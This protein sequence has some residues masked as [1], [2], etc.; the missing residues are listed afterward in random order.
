M[1]FYHLNVGPDKCFFIFENPNSTEDFNPCSFFEYEVLKLRWYFIF[2]FLI[3]ND[4]L[5]SSCIIDFK[6]RA[7]ILLMMVKEG[8]NNNNLYAKIWISIYEIYLPG[9]HRFHQVSTSHL[10]QFQRLQPFSKSLEH[11]SFAS[12]VQHHHHQIYFRHRV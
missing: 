10:G 7:H 12:L 11:N 4:F 6:D 8:S 2:T 9:R 5:R 1:L 3:E